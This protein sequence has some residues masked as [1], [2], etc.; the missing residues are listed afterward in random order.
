MMLKIGS[1]ALALGLACASTTALAAQTAKYSDFNKDGC[2]DILWRNAGTGDTYLH[3]MQGST[4]LG[5]EG[6]VRTVADPNWRIA[7]LG[8]FDGDGRTDVLWRN[9]ATGDNYVHFMNGKTIVSEGLLRAV[10]DQAF[11]VAGVGDFDGDGKADILWRNSVTGVNYLWP[12]DG[13]AIK[14]TEGF[15]R[16]VT[17]QDWQVAGVDDFDGNNTADILWRNLATGDTYF[18]PMNGTTILDTEGYGRAVTDPSWR[19]VGIGDF[20]GDGRADVLWR[21]FA[22]GQNYAHFMNGRVIAAEGFVRSMDTNWKVQATGDY[23][24]D[25]KADILWRHSAS[26]DNQIQFMDGISTKGDGS[27]R[28]VPDFAWQ[29]APS[30]GTTSGSFAFVTGAATGAPG[31]EA[32]VAIQRAGGGLGTYDLYYSLIG[33]GCAM[34]GTIG[35][36]RFAEGGAAV[37]T[38]PV[39][40]ASKGICSAILTTPS[41]VIGGQRSIEVTAVPAVPGCPAPPADLLYSEFGGKGNPIIQRQRSGRV[42][43][44]E[45][46]AT[47]PGSSSGQVTFTE[48][49]GAANTPQPVMLEI[50]ISRCPG[51]IESNYAGMCSLSSTN[52][53]Y[54]S[55]TWLSKKYSIFDAGNSY[56][57]GLCWAGESQKYYVN[58]RW[59][60]S[61]CAFGATTCGFAVQRN[62]G[63]Y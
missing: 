45:L 52:G 3:P 59:T 42:V 1:A 27:T 12:M 6:L 22:N 8:D 29:V 31:E 24:C 34:T 21:N 20:N 11:Q 44:F 26:G 50:S 39:P 25:G 2:S 61:S 57:Y 18:W 14:G 28:T 56:V 43:F 58:A 17:G 63:P 62:D 38:I 33:S 13:L 46:P 48:S 37:N 5:S 41:G 16:T 32:W 40:L 53:N 23:D 49:A 15:L 51:V 35:P 10:T 19:I 36:V 54:N 30:R 47:S 4:I 9:S 60:Y 7:G 55:I